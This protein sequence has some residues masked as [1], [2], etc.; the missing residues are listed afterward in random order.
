MNPESLLP[1]IL[2]ESAPTSLL[3]YVNSAYFD[4]E[5][6]YFGLAEEPEKFYYKTLDVLFLPDERPEQYRWRHLDLN[7]NL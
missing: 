5:L 2:S 6:I 4:R 7:C 3:G 1:M